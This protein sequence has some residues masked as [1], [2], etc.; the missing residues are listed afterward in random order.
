MTS[1]KN[2]DTSS[3]LAQEALLD[4]FAVFYQTIPLHHGADLPLLG[5]ILF[6]AGISF[7][8]RVL[9]VSP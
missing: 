3:A 7:I 5:I 8:I 6:L 2:R 9:S 1:R 4:G